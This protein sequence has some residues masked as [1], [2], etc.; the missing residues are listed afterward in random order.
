[1]GRVDFREVCGSWKNSY[2]WSESTCSMKQE[3]LPQKRVFHWLCDSQFGSPLD[4][5]LH[6]ICTL[7]WTWWSLR[8][9]PTWV[10]L[11]SYN[12]A[13]LFFCPCKRVY[14]KQW[15]FARQ[16]FYPRYILSS[17]AAEDQRIKQNCHILHWSCWDMGAGI[18]PTGCHWGDRFDHRQM[19][20]RGDFSNHS[21]KISRSSS[22]SSLQLQSGN[23]LADSCPDCSCSLSLIHKH[24]CMCTSK[25]TSYR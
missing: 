3:P 13:T 14:S 17:A 2:L 10:I 4:Y 12:S 19:I 6:L 22:V 15:M 20:D 7:S 18:H 25:G 16:S 8:Y 9:F 11:W 23:I 24:M 5:C 21:S 1:M